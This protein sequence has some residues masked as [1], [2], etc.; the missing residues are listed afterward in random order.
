MEK[1]FSVIQQALSFVK[2]KRD[3]EI[4]KETNRLIEDLLE[5]PKY[6]S[7]KDLLLDYKQQ[8]EMYIFR[9]FDELEMLDYFKDD[10]A[11]LLKEEDINFIIESIKYF[12]YPYRDISAYEEVR[13][14]LL[15]RIYENKAQLTETKIKYKSGKEVAGI[16]KNWF[17]NYQLHFDHN[18]EFRIGMM[19]YL[20]TNIAIQELNKNEKEAVKNL[21]YVIE[22]LRTDAEEILIKELDVLYNLGDDLVAGYVDGE[23]AELEP[24]S[25]FEKIF[26]F[27]TSQRSKDKNSVNEKATKESQEQSIANAQ[28]QILKR[29]VALSE[30]EKINLRNITKQYDTIKDDEVLDYLWE[31]I[32]S[33]NKYLVIGALRELAKRGKWE[34]IWEVPRLRLLLNDFRSRKLK[35]LSFDP[36][37]TKQ[38]LKV[39]LKFLLEHHLSLPKDNA[40]KW[41][42]YLVSWLEKNGY[43]QYSDLIYFD[44]DQGRL[45]WE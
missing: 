3:L 14:K 4:A 21:I 8:I 1:V 42:L 37:D 35:S 38:K 31:G 12:L 26:D 5:K 41:A 10:V 39:L 23:Y 28:N 7:N 45:E 9:Y 24:D 6:K 33:Y 17:K 44:A 20:D 27:V 13:E 36:N 15:Q 25:Q 22:Y 32:D 29:K 2:D 11:L 19:E 30:E 34:E 40:K 18:K 16:V 43:D